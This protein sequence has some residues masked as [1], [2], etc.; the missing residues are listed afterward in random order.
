MLILSQVKIV[1]NTFL[2]FFIV[3]YLLVQILLV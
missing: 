2:Q 3:F 1:V